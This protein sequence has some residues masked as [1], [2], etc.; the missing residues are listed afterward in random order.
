MQTS[1]AVKINW[2]AMTWILKP[3][4]GEQT[5]GRGSI[6]SIGCRGHTDLSSDL[7]SVSPR[8]LLQPK[9]RPFYH[10]IFLTC[11]VSPTS[12]W[13]VLNNKLLLLLE[14]LGSD[15][16]GALST[17]LSPS[18]EFEVLS[19]LWRGKMGVPTFMKS[20]PHGGLY[21][22]TSWKGRVMHSAEM[23]HDIHSTF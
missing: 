9:N 19:V 16:E 8:T 23:W 22:S 1:F 21:K 11:V 4:W 13:R 5:L 12:A 10:R 2:E 3:F 15:M 7:W 6:W 20:S 18:G 17:K 14:K